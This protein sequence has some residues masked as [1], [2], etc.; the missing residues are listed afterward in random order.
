M[1]LTEKDRLLLKLF[2]ES[3]I[4]CE[5]IT[6]ILKDIDIDNESIV[7]LLLLGVL[8]YSINWKWFPKDIVPRIKGIHQYY[9]VRNTAV[10]PWVFRQV[11]RLE[12]NGISVMLTG[13][14]AMLHAY[15]KNVPRLLE[16]YDFTVSSEDYDRAADLLR[17][18]LAISD[19]NDFR[20]RT[21][22]GYTKIHLH[23][24]VHD[25]RLMEEKESWERADSVYLN[26]YLV[27]VPSIEEQLLSFLCVPYMHWVIHEKRMDRDYR[28]VSVLQL[29]KNKKVDFDRLAKLANQAHLDAHLRLFLSVLSPYVKEF[30][31]F[32]L[33][34]LV[35]DKAY[36]RY[37]RSLISY[38]K[39]PNIFHEYQ[40]RK[41][42]FQ[43]GNDASFFLFYVLNSRDIHSCKEAIS[44][45]KK[46]I[47]APKRNNMIRG[48]F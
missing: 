20:D 2:S 37:L 6:A 8:G 26:S 38:K 31:Y 35:P 7:F 16:G 18:A 30:R 48:V 44:Y 4:D 43:G 29:V 40:V 13:Q 33:Q 45:V 15:I 24:G 14:A 46:K 32:N 28:L 23:R 25:H 3:E 12:R 9:H 1:L 17:D 5:T 27:R 42:A 34:M 10:L 47:S 36:E 39:H 22:N 11:E 21:I 41:T 19:E